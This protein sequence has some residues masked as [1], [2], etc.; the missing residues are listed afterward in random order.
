MTGKKKRHSKA[1]APKRAARTEVGFRSALG[2]Y[3]VLLLAGVFLI[4]FFRHGMTALTPP[5]P[6]DATPVTIAPAS[7]PAPDPPA[8]PASTR[9]GE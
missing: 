2:L 7:A 6:E 4:W 9:Y 3:V 1:R 8:N 5:E